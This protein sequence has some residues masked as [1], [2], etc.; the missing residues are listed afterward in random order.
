MCGQYSDHCTE[1]SLLIFIKT[2][3]NSPP[4]F[5]SV[6]WKGGE[7]RSP[8]PSGNGFTIC[9]NHAGGM[10]GDRRSDICP[11][12]FRSSNMRDLCPMN[13]TWTLCH[14]LLLGC[15]AEAQSPA[16]LQ[17]TRSLCDLIL[18]ADGQAFEDSLGLSIFWHEF[19]KLIP[20]L[21]AFSSTPS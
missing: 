20:M 8:V 17:P 4:Q 9:L 1:V 14:T 16:L 3:R 10:E 13:S 5:F 19:F 2:H 15:S 12:P 18:T 11:A 7:E 21:A 6:A